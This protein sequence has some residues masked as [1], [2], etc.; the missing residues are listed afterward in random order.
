[1]RNRKKDRDNYRLSA[2]L[3]CKIPKVI[4]YFRGGKMTLVRLQAKFEGIDPPVKRDH[5]AVRKILTR[6]A[7]RLN[8][9]VPKLSDLPKRPTKP[10]KTYN[11][12]TFTQWRLLRYEALK[13]ADGKCECCGTT[14]E[15]SPLHVDHIK[16]KSVHPDKEYGVDDLQVLCEDCNIGKG[17]WDETDWRT[18]RIEDNASQVLDLEHLQKLN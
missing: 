10:N 11:T 4:A 14:A 3:V 15:N 9:D 6:M 12:Q 2:S 16:P 1:M 7:K 13:R 18:K 17:N 8:V 5:E